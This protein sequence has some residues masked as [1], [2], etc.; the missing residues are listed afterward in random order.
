[1]GKQ[2]RNAVDV[3]DIADVAS[4]IGLAACLASAL[5][6]SFSSGIYREPDEQC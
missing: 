4:Y 3:A 6:S 2:Q 5:V 1:L